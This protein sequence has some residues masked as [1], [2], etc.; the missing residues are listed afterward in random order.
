MSYTHHIILTSILFFQNSL[1]NDS[2]DLKN[3]DHIHFDIQPLYAPEIP[4]EVR[5]KINDELLKQNLPIRSAAPSDERQI[6]F[7]IE[8]LYNIDIIEESNEHVYHIY[9][10]D[11]QENCDFPQNINIFNENEIREMELMFKSIPLF[12]QNFLQTLHNPAF[13]NKTAASVFIKRDPKLNTVPLSKAIAHEMSKYGWKSTIFS[14]TPLI[15]TNENPIS[16]DSRNISI[17]F[18]KALHC[19]EISNSPNVLII[20]ELDKLLEYTQEEFDTS[21]ILINCLEKQDYY[22]KFLF[23]GI[24]GN[25]KI[26]HQ[27]SAKS[28]LQ[29]SHN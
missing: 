27:F 12:N 2:I 16:I 21:A 19:V 29:K 11:V 9:P 20:N 28:R 25:E 1:S 17:E 26:F 5:K 14:I 23:I 10:Q 13:G 4:E 15:K 22:K 7:T 18:L 24:G 6:I 3:I 8:P